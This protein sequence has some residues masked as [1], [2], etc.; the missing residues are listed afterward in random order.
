MCFALMK[1]RCV[2]KWKGHE[3]VSGEHIQ[4]KIGLSGHIEQFWNSDI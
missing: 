4:K 2:C 1:I 3:K